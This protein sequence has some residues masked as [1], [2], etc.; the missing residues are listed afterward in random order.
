MPKSPR[1][2]CRSKAQEQIS[3]SFDTSRQNVFTET[4]LRNFLRTHRNAWP[5]S[6]TFTRQHIIEFLCASGTL[7]EVRFRSDE[8]DSKLL[9]VWR[10]ATDRQLVSLILSIGPTVML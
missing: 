3:A 7:Q 5:S 4:Q 2:I 8:Y 9:Y 6:K 1:S 10:H